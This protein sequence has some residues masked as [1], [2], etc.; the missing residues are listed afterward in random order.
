M[1]PAVFDYFLNVAVIVILVLMLIGL[2]AALVLP[3][4]DK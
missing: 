3:R 4:K 2:V 1:N